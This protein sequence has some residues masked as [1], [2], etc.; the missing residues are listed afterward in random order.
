M[1]VGSERGR[2]ASSPGHSVRTTSGMVRS[3]VPGAEGAARMDR[4]G[5]GGEG[6][7]R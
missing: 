6:D 5:R 2:A 4:G 1:C 3:R 7:G